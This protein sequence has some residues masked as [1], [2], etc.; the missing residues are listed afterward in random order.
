VAR[1][2]AADA[3]EVMRTASEAIPAAR[4]Y[5][6][7][8]GEVMRAASG[9]LPAGEA[10]PVARAYGAA[11]DGSS[12]LVGRTGA[13]LPVVRIS[14]APSSPPAAAAPLVARSPSAAPGR[15]EQPRSSPA[16]SP[17][18]DMVWRAAALPASTNA[19]GGPSA[20]APSRATPVI[21]RETTSAPS[22]S[23]AS[24]VAPP[25]PPAAAAPAMPD[26][27]ALAEQVTRKIVR[28]IEVE[29]ERRGGG[30]WP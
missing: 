25:P 18:P 24:S 3:G 29:R 8:A 23:S 20:I 14:G 15:A 22:G 28:Q 6:A 5:P 21:Q 10:M 1:V 12:D 30:R 7:D 4:A 27:D 26:L 11:Q 17:A 19:P 13:P 2:H 9:A 16:G